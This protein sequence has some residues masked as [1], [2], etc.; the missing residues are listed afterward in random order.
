MRMSLNTPSGISLNK[1]LAVLS[2]FIVLIAIL[3][4]VYVGGRDEAG[5]LLVSLDERMNEAYRAYNETASGEAAD[6]L[7]EYVAFLKVNEGK[8]NRHRKVDLLVYVAEAKLGV[9]SMYSDDADSA[10]AHFVAAYRRHE[11]TRKAA[12]ME[13]VK[14]TEFVDFILDATMRVDEASGVTW[15][16]SSKPNSNTV[17]RTQLLLSKSIN[18]ESSTSNEHRENE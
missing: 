4:A 2:A 1:S 11:R 9:L 14:P 6:R 15:R 8:L 17:A 18:G 7:K 5:E 10:S 16:F 12:S 3:V 13:P